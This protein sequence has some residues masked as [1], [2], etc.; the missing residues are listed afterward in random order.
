MA[1][2]MEQPGKRHSKPA[3]MKILSSPSASAW[4]F[5]CSEPGTTRACTPAA[6]FTFATAGDGGGR[7]QILDAAVG[8]RTDEHLVDGHVG[9]L[10]ARLR[11]M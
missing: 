8:A 6:T 11:S 9:E 3:S 10:L 1:R 2:H 4:A 5:T 7:A